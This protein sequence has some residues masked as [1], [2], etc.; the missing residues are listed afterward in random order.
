MASIS[1]YDSAE[2]AGPTHTASSAIATCLARASAS[3]CTATVAMPSLRQDSITRHA[4][5]PRLAISTLSPGDAEKG[6]G[7]GAGA[8]ESARRAGATEAAAARVTVVVVVRRAPWRSSDAAD[9][10]PAL[11]LPPPRPI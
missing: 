9:I 3:E 1:R 10:E 4:I 6:A 8:E 5:S 7:A 2:G 11:P